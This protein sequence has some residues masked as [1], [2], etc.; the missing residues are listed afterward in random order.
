MIASNWYRE[1]LYRVQLNF[2]VFDIN[3]LSKDSITSLVFSVRL[4]LDYP[5][6]ASLYLTESF[7]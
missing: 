5:V 3:I 7:S 6:I 2:V 1:K 4:Q